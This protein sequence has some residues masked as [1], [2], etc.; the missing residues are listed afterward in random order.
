MTSRTITIDLQGIDI[1]V[2]VYFDY[3]PDEPAT[4]YLGSGY[5]FN[6]YEWPKDTGLTAIAINDRIAELEADGTIERI[7][8]ERRDG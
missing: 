1:E 7:L 4:G 6:M 3:D 8:E 2:D 5:I